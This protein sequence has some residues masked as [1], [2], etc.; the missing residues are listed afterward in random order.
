[1]KGL[2]IGSRGSA[3]ALWQ[4]N[5]IRGRL[6]E[7]HGIE[8]DIIVI[9][10]SGDRFQSLSFPSMDGKGVFIKELEDALLE[11][12]IDLAVHSMKDVPTE[13]PAGLSIAA[14]PAREDPRDCVV[15]RGN[16]S[17]AELAPGARVGTSSMRRQAQ[18]LHFRPDLQVM[19]LRGNVDTR[20]RKLDEGQCDAVVL[21][22]AGLDRLGLAQRASEILDAK[23]M[24]PA[25]GQ[26]ALGIEARAADAEVLAI[27]DSLEDAPTRLCV[28]AERAMLAELEGGCQVPVGALARLQDEELLL[29]GC[30]LSPDGTQRLRETAS[31]PKKDAERIGRSLG[32]ALRN[33]GA[34]KI[35]EMAGKANG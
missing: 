17:L 15:A 8:S 12:L 31:G 22:K 21:A 27:L 7:M 1:V 2:R 28:A 10:T 19:G 5:H 18:I 34:D 26:G 24:L 33:A 3:L 35:L 30:V 32:R 14:I 4:A 13:T 11:N 29:E 20:L 23:V 25:A 16:G 6:R 9:R